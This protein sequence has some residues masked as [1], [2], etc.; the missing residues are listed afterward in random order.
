MARKKSENRHKEIDKS[1]KDDSERA[2]RVVEETSSNGKFSTY[3]L[4][5][6]KDARDGDL[7]L[8]YRGEPKKD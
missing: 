6:K 8:Q 7:I 1:V 5:K 3:E 4:A 2:A